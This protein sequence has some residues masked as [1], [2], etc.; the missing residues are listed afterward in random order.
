ML[1]SNDPGKNIQGNA[2]ANQ[3]QE[4]G[5]ITSLLHHYDI[6][7]FVLH[8]QFMDTVRNT[9]ELPLKQPWTTFSDLLLGFKD[10]QGDA[11]ANQ[12]KG[13]GPS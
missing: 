9:K 11:V 1:W 13:A 4:A 7:R 8:L 2:V 5:H 3:N 12:I 10:L 6:M